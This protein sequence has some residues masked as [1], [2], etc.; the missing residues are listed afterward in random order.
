MPFQSTLISTFRINGIMHHCGLLGGFSRRPTWY[1]FFFKS[2][3][4]ESQL[5]SSPPVSHR[6][7][8]WREGIQKAA[9]RGL[10]VIA[11]VKND[12]LTSVLTLQWEDWGQTGQSFSHYEDQL[13]H[14]QMR[15]EA[16]REIKSPLAHCKKRKKE[17]KPAVTPQTA[18]QRFLQIIF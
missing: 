10:W 12:P 3:L 13:T 2:F 8:F 17:R 15:D 7:R 4:C 6:E 11:K 1:F 5:S 9:G 18:L 14:P 16:A